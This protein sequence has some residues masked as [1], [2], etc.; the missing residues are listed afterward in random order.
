MEDIKNKSVFSRPALVISKDDREMV[1]PGA[2]GL[3]FRQYAAVHIMASL[4]NKS[5]RR[6]AAGEGIAEMALRY[7]DALIA[8]IQSEE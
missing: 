6:V 2:D 7:A 3:T 1:E 4:V 5:D 8:K